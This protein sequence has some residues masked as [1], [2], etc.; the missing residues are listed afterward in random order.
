MVRDDVLLCGDD[1]REPAGA[2]VLRDRG[3][4]QYYPRRRSHD[5]RPLD[6]QGGLRGPAEPVARRMERRYRASRM[7]DQQRGRGRKVELAIED[8]EVMGD[9]RRAEAVDDDDRLPLA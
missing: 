8:P 9:R 5:V 1:L 2:L 6:V 3:L 4:D 7:N